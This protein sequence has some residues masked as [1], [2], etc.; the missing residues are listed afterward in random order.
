[1]TC[2]CVYI[3]LLV[4]ETVVSPYYFNGTC[5]GFQYTI[6]L[7]S[8]DL[9]QQWLTCEIGSLAQDKRCVMQSVEGHKAFPSSRKIL[10][11]LCSIVYKVI[12]WQTVNSSVTCYIY[13][14]FV[15]ILFCNI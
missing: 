1:M 10:L 11:S 2:A 3:S 12:R 6:Y 7:S 9:I 5:D 14:T 13:G 15:T 4:L 8:L